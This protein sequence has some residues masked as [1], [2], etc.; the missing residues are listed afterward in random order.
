[1][2]VKVLQPASVHDDTK[3]K[4]YKNLYFSIGVYAILYRQ[5][6]EY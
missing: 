2:G 1:M 5:D 6:K 3:K 4:A